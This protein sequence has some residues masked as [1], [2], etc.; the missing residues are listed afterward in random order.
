MV[1]V[2][3]SA[4]LCYEHFN[5]TLLASMLPATFG[6]ASRMGENGSLS[7]SRE[8]ILSFLLLLSPSYNPDKGPRDHYNEAEEATLLS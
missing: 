5:P 8:V 7:A 4:K 1:I 3:F 6:L 2:S